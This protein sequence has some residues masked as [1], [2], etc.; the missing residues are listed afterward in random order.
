MKKYQKLVIALLTINILISSTAFVM[1]VYTSQQNRER[2]EGFQD[3]IQS[4]QNTRETLQGLFNQ[5]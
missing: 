4:I 3:S 5:N 2:L 1:I